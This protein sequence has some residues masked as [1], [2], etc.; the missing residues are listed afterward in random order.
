MRYRKI[1]MLAGLVFAIAFSFGYMNSPRAGDLG[2]PPDP[3]PEWDCTYGMD[4]S[5]CV[6]TL[7]RH[8]VF[9]DNQCECMAFPGWPTV[10]GPCGCQID[11]LDGDPQQ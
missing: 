9:I 6:D 1:S 4:G 11:C 3:P 5:C 7:G 2:P 10:N 8:G